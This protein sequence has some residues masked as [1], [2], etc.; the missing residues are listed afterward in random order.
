MKRQKLSVLKPVAL[1]ATGVFLGHGA[2]ATT[3]ITF[4]GFDTDNINISEIAN[5]GDNVAASSPDYTVSV[6]VGGILGTPAIGLTW[7]AGYQS[8]TAWDRRG[9]V[10]QTDFNA[11]W[12]DPGGY[13]PIDLVFTPSAGFGA[14]VTSFALDEYGGGGAGWG[15]PAYGDTSVSWSLFDSTGTLASGVWDLRNNANDP[16]DAGGRNTILTG[17]TPASISGLPVTLRLI[18]NSGAP[19]YLALDNLIFDQVVVVP[20]PGVVSLGLL[21]AGL[22]ALALRRRKQA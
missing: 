17:L 1:V 19:S 22:G 3:W 2:Y 21:G 14:L 7:G 11:T 4:Q 10:G 6:G 18:M 15:D 16:G 13:G 20:E 8:Y 9:N 12:T 5:Y